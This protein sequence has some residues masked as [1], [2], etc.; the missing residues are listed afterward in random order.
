MEFSGELQAGG[1][2]SH[3]Q[4]AALGDRPAC[5]SRTVNC[6][7]GGSAVRAGTLGRLHAPLAMTTERLRTSPVLVETIAVT[8]AG[9]GGDRGVGSTARATRRSRH[10]AA[11]SAAVM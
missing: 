4:H 5:D 2:R 8:V 11:T 9:D 6:S 7:D 1:R 3:H 10:E